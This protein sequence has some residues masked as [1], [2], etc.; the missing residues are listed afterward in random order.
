MT[1]PETAIPL[2]LCSGQVDR[3][4]K[5]IEVEDFGYTPKPALTEFLFLQLGGFFL[6]SG[7]GGLLFGFSF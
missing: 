4:Y 7:F 3:G 6:F 1:S 5:K 2:R